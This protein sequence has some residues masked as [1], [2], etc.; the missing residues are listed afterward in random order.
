VRS[1]KLTALASAVTLAGGLL[2]P[3]MEASAVQLSALPAVA[4]VATRT[5]Q[6]DV[7]GDHHDDEV[8]VEQNGTDT[9]VV[10][11]VTWAGQSDVKQFTSTIDDDWGLEPWYGAAKLNGRKGYEL[12][13]LTS[14]GDGV[15]FRVLSWRSGELAWDKAP[16]SRMKGAYGWYLADLD[17]ARFGYRFATSAAGKRYVRDFEL[18]PSGSKWKGTV[19]NSVWKSGAWHKVSTHK[20]TLTAGQANAYR[21]ISG[22]TIIDQ[23]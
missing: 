9:F 7:D 2:V 20:V 16:K 21:N 22:V 23:P 10:N 19:V 11:V 14:G 13:L 18:Y 4:P 17:F 15:M 1:V 8:T 6:V 3:A 5:V 12:L